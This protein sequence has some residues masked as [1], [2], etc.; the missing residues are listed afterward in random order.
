MKSLFVLTSDTQ[1]LGQAEAFSGD[2]LVVL[3]VVS[4][5]T[6]ATNFDDRLAALERRAGEIQ[7]ALLARGK[8]CRVVIEW[9]EKSEAVN[10]ALLRERAS[11][12]N[13]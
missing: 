6:L 1:P 8:K 3:V 10:N 11:L 5:N 7:H 12:L 2:E 13:A 9:G 4:R